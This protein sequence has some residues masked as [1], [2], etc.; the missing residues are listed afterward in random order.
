MLQGTNRVHSDG[1]RRGGT[2]H[3]GTHRAPS[4]TEL[5]MNEAAALPSPAVVLSARLD[6]YYDR[7][8]L[9]PG[10]QSISRLH[11]G[12]RTSRP[13]QSQ[14][15]SAGEGLSSS[16]RHRLNVPR[17][18][19]PGSPSRLRFQA[20]H[21][22]HGLHREPLGSALPQCLTTRQASLPLRTA[23]SLP[24][25]GLSTLGFDPTRFQTRAASLLPGLLAATRTGLTPAGDD[26]L[27]TRTRP[28]DDHLLITGRTGWSISPRVIRAVE[29][30]PW[31]RRG[32][33]GG[34]RRS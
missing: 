32:R 11:T 26:E 7:L 14:G 2:S 19:T 29:R 18:L 10:T 30:R 16:R 34:P 21:R 8:R 20:L 25:Q 33:E 23:D 31:R 12:Y 4:L 5:R 24:P 27:Q 1:S 3:I 9:P 6:R 17:P 28:L 13:R 22:F 15:A